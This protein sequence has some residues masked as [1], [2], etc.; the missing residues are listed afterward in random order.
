MV[1]QINPSASLN[2]V[3]PFQSNTQEMLL[4]CCLRG[5][6]LLEIQSYINVQEGQT[7][8]VI[9]LRP[10]LPISLAKQ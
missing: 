2:T 1:G 8:K 7:L 3:V 4:L 5:R 9:N 10:V 6:H